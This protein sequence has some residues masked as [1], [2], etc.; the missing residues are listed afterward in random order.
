MEYYYTQ[1]HQQDEGGEENDSVKRLLYFAVY[2][3][4]D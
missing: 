3:K 2:D 1:R 4:K